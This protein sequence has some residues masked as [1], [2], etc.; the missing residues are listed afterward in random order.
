MSV[1]DER[2]QQYID[3]S[4]GA[5]TTMRPIKRATSGRHIIVDHPMDH[6]R[7]QLIDT[8]FGIPMGHPTARTEGVRDVPWDSRWE[9]LSDKSHKMLGIPWDILHDD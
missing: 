5:F 4:K 1:Q 3:A 7:R 2:V 8:M 9:R 6:S